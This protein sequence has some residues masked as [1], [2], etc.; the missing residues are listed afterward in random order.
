MSKIGFVGLGAMGSGMALNLA[1]KAQ[2]V[3]VFDIRPEACDACVQAG[4]SGRTGSK[5]CW[6]AILS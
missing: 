2:G 3:M 1:K 5:I 6:C 4:R